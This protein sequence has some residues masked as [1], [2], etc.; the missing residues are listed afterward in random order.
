MRNKIVLIVGLVIA[1]ISQVHG[2]GFIYNINWNIGIP[3]SDLKDF[4]SDEDISL[5][6]VSVD[7][8]RFIQDNITVGGYFAWDFFNGSTQEMI[9][10]DDVDVSG[11]QR[12]FVNSFPI[13]LNSHYYFKKQGDVR[14]YGG[15]GL[16]VVRSLQ[17][18][19][20]GTFDFQNNNWHFGLYPEVGL[21]IPVGEY[22]NAMVGG[23]Y[24]VA[25]ATNDS[26]DYTYFSINIGISYSF[27]D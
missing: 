10:I 27:L 25:F 3:T 13:M 15:I 16:G 23:K 20:I 21:L 4:L 11:F 6:G 26:I 12:M 17:R 2:Q 19:S 8:R 18:V 5:G 1:I 14:P 22:G 9:N 7:Y 24:M